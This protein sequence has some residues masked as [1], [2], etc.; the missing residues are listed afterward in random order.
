MLWLRFNFTFII[1]RVNAKSKEQGD[2]HGY[3]AVE[4]LSLEPQEDILPFSSIQDNPQSAI[5]VQHREDL[6]EDLSDNCQQVDRSSNG[7]LVV[8]PSTFSLV[9][10]KC[11]ERVQKDENEVAEKEKVDEVFGILSQKLV[12]FGCLKEITETMVSYGKLIS[13]HLLLYLSFY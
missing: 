13:K 3:T 11:S 7:E 4:Q 8:T 2:R 6:E 9:V 10:G 12:C 5:T 1:D